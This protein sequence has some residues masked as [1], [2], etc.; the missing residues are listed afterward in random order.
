MKWYSEQNLI[1]NVARFVPW[2]APGIPASF[3]YINSLIYLTDKWYFALLIAAT[4]EFLG[5]AS[6]HTS[7]SLFEYVKTSSKNKPIA[8]TWIIAGMTLFYLIL[9]VVVNIILDLDI[10]NKAIIAKALL[11][12]VS[13]PAAVTLSIRQLHKT[14]LTNEAKHKAEKT[15]QGKLGALTKKHNELQ[16]AN[17]ELATTIQGLKQ[18]LSQQTKQ[19]K[20]V[21]AISKTAS[22]S[23]AKAKQKIELIAC[24]DCGKEVKGIKGLN[25]HKA[26][27]E[28][29]QEIEVYSNG[30]KEIA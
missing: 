22:K 11:S 16:Q 3:A 7:L 12:L 10:P 4:V 6:V 29:K 13:I 23:K 17:K 1:D 28:G 21:Q 24:P 9:V 5:L 26:W 20:P 14:R 8:E 25:G 30:Y 18:Q 15:A 2:L 27:C 19:A